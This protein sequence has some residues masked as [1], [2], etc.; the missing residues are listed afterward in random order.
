[1]EIWEGLKNNVLEDSFSPDYNGWTTYRGWSLAV[2]NY[3][4][5]R[6]LA[7][8]A[9]DTG[10]KRMSRPFISAGGYGR[11]EAKWKINSNVAADFSAANTFADV[12]FMID[13]IDA[14]TLTGANKRTIMLS[15]EGAG[16]N[17]GIK[18]WNGTANT[19]ILTIASVPV[20]TWL[21]VSLVTDG[22]GRYTA[23]VTDPAGVILGSIQHQVAADNGKQLYAFVDFGW[24][25]L[26]NQNTWG[27]QI[28]MKDI[29]A[30]D[31]F[32]RYDE[33]SQRRKIR[34]VTYPNNDACWVVIPANWDP[35]VDNTKVII[36]GH[37][38][39]ATLSFATMLSE[40]FPDAGFIY[41]QSN[42]H[43]N[44]WGNAT[45]TSDLEKMRQWIVEKCGGS[46]QVYTHGS[47]MGNLA[48]LNYIAKYPEKVRKHV[49]E[50]GVC[51]LQDLYK[52]GSFVASIQS[53]YGVTRFRDIPRK[54]DPIQNIERY[55]DTP[56]M[57]WAGTSDT[58]V[59]H[60]L[61][62]RPFTDKLAKLGGTVMYLEEPGETH[63]LDVD[64]D[65]Y[66]DFYTADIGLSS[67]SKAKT[68]LVKLAADSTY[69]IVTSA[70]GT[71]SYLLD[72][73]QGA[74]TAITG[75]SEAIHTKN[76]PQLLLLKVTD[77]KYDVSNITVTK[78]G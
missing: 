8:K 55:V 65:R 45:A 33:V 69:N 62:S 4:G 48:A 37:G 12:G 35:A 29:I 39:N 15:Y 64:P 57:L 43:G 25:Q 73:N 32:I 46:E 16:S 20:D 61:N 71:V 67:K 1:L 21:T 23:T 14:S 19:M 74:L 78:I 44:S 42:T 11:I 75:L 70:P 68:A 34:L 5:E 31:D 49:G 24:A 6:V 56:I 28:V 72:A 9:G 52:D 22:T 10:S 63:S 27:T 36:A 53:M 66:V 38:Y 2:I 3:A 7:G 47:S 58:T 17:V 60:G 59:P 51:S 77:A 76:R 54:Y 26:T 40:P 13:T 41:A 50:I 18:F 30:R